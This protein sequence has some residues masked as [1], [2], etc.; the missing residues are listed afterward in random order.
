MLQIFAWASVSFLQGYPA[1][2]IGLDAKGVTWRFMGSYKSGYRG[3]S[4]L[5]WVISIVILLITL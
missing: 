3:I 1:V 5:I 2:A 4:P